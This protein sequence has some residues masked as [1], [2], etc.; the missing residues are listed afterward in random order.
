VKS[1]DNVSHDSVLF[2]EMGAELNAH[3]SDPVVD[4]VRGLLSSVVV[5]ADAKQEPGVSGQSYH[6]E[7]PPSAGADYCFTLWL[8]SGQKQISARL[9]N[10]EK[11]SYFWYR[12]FEDAE[13]RSAERLDKAFLEAVEVI[14]RHNTRIE[15]KHGFLFEHFKCEYES[16]SGWKRLYGHADLRLIP[17]LK[18]AGRKYVYQSP[19]LVPDVAPPQLKGG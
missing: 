1:P 11:S 13:F 2:K 17:A 5:E 19:P 6:I 16:A 3:L 15:R 4:F 12:P 10:A 14:M 7:L 18:T 8:G 9:L